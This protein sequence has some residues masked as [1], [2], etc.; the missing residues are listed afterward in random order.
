MVVGRF[1]VDALAGPWRNNCSMPTSN[2]D[3]YFDTVADK[4]APESRKAQIWAKRFVGDGHG[5]SSSRINIVEFD[6]EV[7]RLKR[8]LEEVRKKA[9]KFFEVK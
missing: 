8:E 9:H 1:R 4:P 7:D 5:I 2:L 6:N 3:V